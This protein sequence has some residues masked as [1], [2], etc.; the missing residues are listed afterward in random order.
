VLTEYVPA[1]DASNVSAL[2]AVRL[3][4]GLIAGLGEGSA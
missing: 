3:L 4:V 1:L 2:I